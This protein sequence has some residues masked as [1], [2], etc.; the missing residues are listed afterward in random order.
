MHFNNTKLSNSGKSMIFTY[1]PL[2][3]IDIIPDAKYHKKSGVWYNYHNNILLLL[4][5]LIFWAFIPLKSH[6]QSGVYPEPILGYS[7]QKEIIIEGDSVKGDLSDYPLLVN[8][9]GDA[10]L[11]TVSNGGYVYEEDGNDQ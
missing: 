1:F 5:F 9:S 3:L 10:N 11:R 2:S 7:F 8:I 4:S 6:A